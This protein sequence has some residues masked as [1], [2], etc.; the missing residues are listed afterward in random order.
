MCEKNGAVGKR[1]IPT[2]FRSRVPV[3]SVRWGAGMVDGRCPGRQ[4]KGS[5]WRGLR[6]GESLAG[7]KLGFSRLCWGARGGWRPTEKRIL[8]LFGQRGEARR[9]FGLPQPIRLFPCVGEEAP[10]HFS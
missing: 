1:K 6:N 5:G 2:E 9:N 7:V 3:Q 10:S 4:L 8:K